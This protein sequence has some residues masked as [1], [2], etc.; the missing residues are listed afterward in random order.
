M[1]YNFDEIIDRSNSHSYKW[2]IYGKDVLP[3][4]VADM[5][6]RSPQPVIDALSERV[7]HGIF[8]YTAPP[9]QLLENICQHLWNHYQ[10]K[11]NYEDIIFLPGVVVGFNN[12][13][14]AFANPGQGVLMQTPVYHPFLTAPLNGD[15]FR[16]EAPLSCDAQGRYT[17]D[18]GA[19]E[20]AITPQTAM[21]LLCNPHNP[22]GRVFTSVELKAMAEICLRHSLPICSDE[23]HCDLVYAENRHLPIA[24]LNEEIADNCITL[25]A[26]SKTY[27]I[28]GL[29]C[30]FA[31]IQNKALKQKVLAA[32]RG[33]VGGVNLLGYQAALAAYQFG[34]EWLQQLLKYLHGNRKLL[35]D[36]VADNFIGVRLSPLEATYLAWLDFRACNLSGGPY[37]FF[38]EEARVALNDGASFGTGGDGFV[39][40][41]IGCPRS[42]LLEGLNR[43]KTALDRSQG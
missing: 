41:N 17:I 9:P 6:F 5:D 14:Q 12:V 25:M 20:N 15:A 19:F 13:I 1:I 29:D 43:M 2:D 3:M 21:F 11:I 40:L 7:Q 24:S 31:V 33:L 8:G 23:I 42:M 4:W 27:N 16:Q 38:L 28:A 10:W 37:R 36:F 22:V 26:P 32:Q 18:L 39:R 30:S 34:E 35:V